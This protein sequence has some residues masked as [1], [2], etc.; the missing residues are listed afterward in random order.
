VRLVRLEGKLSPT[1]TE[2]LNA[3]FRS[4][5]VGRQ[6][7]QDG[8]YWRSLHHWE[9]ISGA[10]SAIIPGIV[11]KLN[12]NVFY[13]DCRMQVVCLASGSSTGASTPGSTLSAWS[14]TGPAGSAVVLPG[15]LRSAAANGPDLTVQGSIGGSLG[16]YPGAWFPSLGPLA[17]VPSVAIGD[18]EHSKDNEK[19]E[20]T[21]VYDYVG[22]EVWA[23][24][25]LE[26]SLYQRYRYTT[27][28]ALAQQS[29]TV[30]VLNNRIVYR[31]IFTSPI[32]LL[33]NYEGDRSRDVALLTSDAGPWAEAQTNS[34]TLEWLMRWNEVLTTRTRLKGNIEHTS[35]TISVDPQTQVSTPANHTKYAYGGEI[36]FR[37]Y[38][39]PDVSALYIYASTEYKQWDQNGDS[40][41]TAWELLPMFGVIWR[42]GDKLYLDGHFNYDYVHCL[43]GSTCATNSKIMPYVYFTMNL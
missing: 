15:A 36:Q 19:K 28:G 39:L 35:G 32:T 13:D 20:Y 7:D 12:Y 43:S 1:T 38:P 30:T 33:V 8:P 21:R 40:A 18:G 24:R 25:K 3:L 31:P 29:T 37:L 4:R 11:P 16:F 26:V 42:L 14:N 22:A 34:N 27:T 5:D 6:T 10:Q 17:V 41:Y 23:G 9:L 2:S